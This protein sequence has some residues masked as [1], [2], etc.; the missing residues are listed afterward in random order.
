VRSWEKNH[1][2]NIPA[3]AHELAEGLVLAQKAGLDLSAVMEV[4]KVADLPK[5]L[6]SYFFGRYLDPCVLAIA[7]ANSTAGLIAD[8]TN[9]N[10]STIG[11]PGFALYHLRE[12]DNNEIGS[13]SED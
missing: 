11:L 5:R 12:N 10:L 2:S 1:V 3:I 9:L 4:V 6:R 13:L 8:G 7:Q